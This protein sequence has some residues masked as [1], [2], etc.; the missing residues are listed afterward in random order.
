MKKIVLIAIILLSFCMA[1][2]AQNVTSGR[3]RVVILPGNAS[4]NRQQTTRVVNLTVELMERLGRFE[5]IDRRTT[6]QAMEEIKLKLSGFLDENAVIE[7]GNM[8]SS[9]I[10][11]VVDLSY[12]S[13]EQN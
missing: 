2:F 11:M 4:E 7:I 5:V 8:M 12:F 6:D 3:Q 9:D 10:G 1:V 13:V